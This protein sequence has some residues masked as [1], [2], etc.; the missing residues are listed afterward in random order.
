MATRWALELAMETSFDRV[1][2]EGDSQ[3]LITALKNDS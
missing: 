2:L 1:I 3:T